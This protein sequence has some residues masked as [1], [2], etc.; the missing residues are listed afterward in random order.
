MQA[1]M[2]L[3]CFIVLLLLDADAPCRKATTPRRTARNRRPIYHC[4]VHIQSPLT[5]ADAESSSTRRNNLVA[6]SVPAAQASRE[7]GFG[8]RCLRGPFGKPFT[9]STRFVKD[10]FRNHRIA[11]ARKEYYLPVVSVSSQMTRSHSP[12]ASGGGVRY[13][14]RPLLTVDL[15]QAL[16]A[17]GQPALK[18]LCENPAVP[19]GLWFCF[20]SDP[21]LRLPTPIGATEA[22]IG[23][24]GCA[25]SWANGAAAPS[26]LDF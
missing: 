1:F 10:I 2:S 5:Q 21:G 13:R 4:V 11:V 23:D 26:G 8:Q 24:P 12:D 19:E 9:W 14:H 25:A 15:Y 7:A 20:P 22:R 6:P 3:T 16:F 17:A 18:S